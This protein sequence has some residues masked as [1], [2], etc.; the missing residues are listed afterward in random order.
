MST[1]KSTF[2]C[3]LLPEDKIRRITMKELCQESEF[4]F[5]STNALS[6]TKASFILNPEN[7]AGKVT[8]K[9][10]HRNQFIIARCLISKVISLDGSGCLSDLGTVSKLS[11]YVRITFWQILLI[12]IFSSGR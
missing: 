1:Y 5:A 9:R 10:K 2:R 11:S 4:P 8:E 3:P 12:L 7:T 6:G